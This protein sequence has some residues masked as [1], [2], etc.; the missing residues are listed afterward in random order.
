MNYSPIAG[1][2]IG[3][4]FSEMVIL[5]PSNEVYARMKILHDSSANVDKAIELLNK[6]EKDFKVKP[7]VVMES[8]GHYHK[9]LFQ[10][11][12]RAGFAVSVVNPLQTDSIKNIGIRKVKNDKVD[13]RKVA[14]LHRFQEL[15]LTNIPHE[16]IECLKS[17]CRQYYNLSDQIVACKN[18]LIG[19]VDQLML[20]FKDV[21]S[22]I[23]TKTALAIL[24]KY[25]SP[26]HIIKADSKELIALIKSTSVKSVKWS[27]LKYELLLQRATDFEPLSISTT[28]NIAMLKVNISL[29]RTLNE[30][31]ESILNAIHET[32]K[33]DAAK[34]MPMLSLFIDL[35]CTVPG[36]GVLTAATIL[37]EIGNFNIFKKPHKLVA[38]CGIDPS[39]HRSGQFEG[40]QNRMSKRGPRLLRKV[41]FTVALANIR[42]KSNGEKLNP[43]MFEFYRQKCIS[44]AKKVALGAVMHKIVLIL[45]AV[46]RDRKPFELRTPEEHSQVL[47]SKGFVA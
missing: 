20:N 18:R 21:F 22:D 12:T 14:L 17:L 43:V 30:S 26:S 38:Y 1:I 39:V 11:L 31:L 7:A 47:K 13:A 8:T 27:T 44:K 28:A 6:A 3:K 41:L 24:E 45:F 40:T 19:V 34:D 15:K 36:I 33:T 42:K 35:L 29:Y 37:S 25:P 16:D 10:S 9:I 32:L 23:C 4:Y 5:S 46:L 2:D